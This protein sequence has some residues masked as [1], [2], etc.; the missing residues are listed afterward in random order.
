MRGGEKKD[1]ERE[2]GGIQWGGWGG[3]IQWLVHNFDFSHT[4]LQNNVGQDYL[5]T[6][7]NG[8]VYPYD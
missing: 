1:E 7:I 3:G 4:S 2:K 6:N 8:W 5:A